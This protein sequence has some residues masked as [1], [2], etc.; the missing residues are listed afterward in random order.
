[1]TQI[2]LCTEQKQTYRHAE[3]T[4]GCQEGGGR[5]WGGLWVWGR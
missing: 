3:Q 5:E 1:M 4:C 2:N